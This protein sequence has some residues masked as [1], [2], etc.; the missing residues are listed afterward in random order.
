MRRLSFIPTNLRW[1]SLESALVRVTRWSQCPWY[2]LSGE[3]LRLP[4]GVVCAALSVSHSIMIFLSL[5]R[6]RYR[7]VLDLR[8]AVPT[9]HRLPGGFYHLDMPWVGSRHHF[10]LESRHNAIARRTG[11][12]SRDGMKA[13][14]RGGLAR[15]R[16]KGTRPRTSQHPRSHQSASF[17]VRSPTT[18]GSSPGSWPLR[19]RSGRS[20]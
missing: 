16:R 14:C 10:Y 9:A 13:G 3:S 20:G 12:H 17:R 5:R 1:I 18:T 15:R 11:L 7:N 6:R 2:Y 8:R 19:P 4:D